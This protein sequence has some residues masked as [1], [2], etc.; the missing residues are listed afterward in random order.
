MADRSMAAAYWAAHSG[1]FNG[2]SVAKEAHG[3]SRFAA[4]PSTPQRRSWL[5]LRGIPDRPTRFL[6]AAS[7]STCVAPHMAHMQPAGALAFRGTWQDVRERWVLARPQFKRQV[8][9][10]PATSQG[11]SSQKASCGTSNLCYI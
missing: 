4:R 11:P 7:A 2:T 3:V 10:R 6:A 9:Q 8:T 1:A 5:Q